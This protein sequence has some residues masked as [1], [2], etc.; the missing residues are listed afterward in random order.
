MNSL[1]AL[2]KLPH[3][4][5]K[6]S[7]SLSST[8]ALSPYPHILH[9]CLLPLYRIAIIPRNMHSYLARS[10][11]GITLR[12]ILFTELYIS[13]NTLRICR[14]K[15]SPL[16]SSSPLKSISHGI[17]KKLYHNIW[18][19]VDFAALTARSLSD[20]DNPTIVSMSMHL[21]SPLTFLLRYR[22][23]HIVVYFFLSSM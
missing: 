11:P 9:L 12:A 23:S 19:A 10:L 17:F 8:K 21:A 22:F 14:A 6:R 1:L 15:L 13:D 3:L 18:P 7:S 16:S 20:L 2:D 5:H 4:G